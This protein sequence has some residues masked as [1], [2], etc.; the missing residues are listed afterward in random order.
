M[1]NRLP[2][3]AQFDRIIVVGATIA[4]L[5]ALPIAAVLIA[6]LLLDELTAP[7]VVFWAVA[8][9]IVAGA[10]GTVLLPNIVHA[11]V[12]LV[13]TLLG[14]A[15]IY[16]LLGSEF[17]AL[18]QLLVYGGGVTILLL[19]GLMLTRAADDPVIADG[20]QKPF[21]FG[22]A[23]LIGGIFVAAVLDANWSQTD[24]AAIGIRDIGQRLFRDY[25]VPFEIASLVL[26][27]A[28]IGAIAIA[29]SDQPEP[30]AAEAEEVTT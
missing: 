22:V 28:L 23:A 2:I 21:A 19:F 8:A 27:V 16:L 7:E 11:A 9:L 6:L 1:L 15:G 10:L 14:V 12:S 25:G 13:A 20:A 3:P 5:G 17:L 18:V 24:A 30:E 29:R 4:V 26:L